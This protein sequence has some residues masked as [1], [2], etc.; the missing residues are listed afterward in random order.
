[1]LAK[2]LPLLTPPVRMAA[3]WLLGLMVLMIL[4][5]LVWWEID[6]EYS[7]GYLVPLFVGYVLYERY[8]RMGWLL[9]PETQLTP[10]KWERK[11]HGLFLERIKR[12]E[13][14]VEWW[15]RPLEIPAMLAVIVG[16]LMFIWG[17]FYHA[18]EG[19]N[20]VTS[21]FYAAGFA[22]M[23]LG[24]AYLLSAQ[25]LHG[26]ALNGKQRLTFASL[27]VFPSLIWLLSVPMFGS[28]DVAVSTFL[29]FKVASV[30]FHV[31]DALGYVIEQRH[32]VLV[33][34][35]GE[36]GVAEAC[37]GIRSLMAC[38]FAGSFISAIF[39]D[40][41]WKK[42]ALVGTAM[43]L[44]FFNNLLRSLFL[45]VWAYDHGPD[46]LHD[47]V[48]I[49]GYDL[50]NI[51]DFAGN[52]VLVFTVIGLLLLSMVFSIR[53]DY[54]DDSADVDKPAEGEGASPGAE[55]GASA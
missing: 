6:E 7:F 28:L 51:H 27:F 1:M 48:R 53:L 50:G 15:A 46:S 30:V 42:V 49:F 18:L 39:F 14:P 32:S 21:D 9:K 5:Q 41:I 22:G 33:L 35:T 55:S 47:Q 29:M 11:N 52:L 31:M 44:A 4:D 54:E 23:L 16:A 38:L 43:A 25:D 19:R 12:R 2:Y 36:V 40:H 13:G 24:G 17:A 10:T 37:S 34:P 26:Q 8:V 45:T 20:L 3:V